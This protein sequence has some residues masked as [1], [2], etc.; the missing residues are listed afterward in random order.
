MVFSGWFSGVVPPVTADGPR[1]ETPAPVR[2]KE[3]PKLNPYRG[4]EYID[5]ETIEA[6]IRDNNGLELQWLEGLLGT[7]VR[8][9]NITGRYLKKDRFIAAVKQARKDHVHVQEDNRSD[10]TV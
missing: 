10:S 9:R 4:Y 2:K 6:V 1:P 3:E 5:V 7:E 8:V